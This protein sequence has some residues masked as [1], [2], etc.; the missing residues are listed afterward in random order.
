MSAAPGT[1]GSSSPWGWRGHTCRRCWALIGTW[2]WPHFCC[3]PHPYRPLAA[4]GALCLYYIAAGYPGYARK[5]PR[6]LDLNFLLSSMLKTASGSSFKE[7]EV[8]GGRRRAFS[9]SAGKAPAPE[10]VRLPERAVLCEAPT[11]AAAPCV[12]PPGRCGAGLCRRP[13][14]A[15]LQP[16]LAAALSRNLSAMLPSFVFIMYSITVADKSCRAMFYNCDKDLLRYAWYRKPKVILA[17]LRHSP[18]PR[19]PVQRACSGRAVPCGG[20]LLP[21]QRHR[22]FHRGSALFCAALLLLSLC[23]PRTTCAFT[24]S[25]SPIPKA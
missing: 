8:P 1:P 7:V 14:A 17:Q 25:S 23:S 6:S 19:S 15:H 16:E 12:V 18:A 13:R 22:Y 11:A 10:R 20:R 5:L 2:A 24:T 3:I 21:H 9:G 4:A